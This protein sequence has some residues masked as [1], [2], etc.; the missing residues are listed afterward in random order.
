MIDEIAMPSGHRWISN[1][2][3]SNSCSIEASVLVL[4]Q[5]GKKQLASAI[6]RGIRRMRNYNVFMKKVYLNVSL[7]NGG[8]YLVSI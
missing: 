3:T 8:M 6:K 5:S 2:A 7:E 4:V 1:G